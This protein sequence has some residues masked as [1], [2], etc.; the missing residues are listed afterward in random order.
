MQAGALDLLDA[1]GAR[2]LVGADD[3]LHLGGRDGEAGRR[4]PHA[5]AGVV[6][7]GGFVYVACAYEAGEGDGVL[8]LLRLG[9]RFGGGGSCW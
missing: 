2:V 4:G 9:L 7:D 1:V 3:L 8:A 5:V 6:E